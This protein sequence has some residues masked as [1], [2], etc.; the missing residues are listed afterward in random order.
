MLAAWEGARVTEMVVNHRRRE[1]GTT[2]YG[3]GRILNVLWD[4]VTVKFLGTYVT[5]PLYFFGKLG[6][7]SLSL[8][9][10]ALGVAIAQK[11]G[12]LG[13]PQGLHL[14]RNVLVAL[15]ALLC[16]C[17]VQCILFGIVSEFL[18]RIYHESRRTRPYRIRTI[19]RADAV[20]ESGS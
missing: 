15:A 9:A 1:R 12:Y 8:S 19:H 20:S 4:L 10:I 18:V 6:L 16:F 7:L 14:N 17:T 13:Q 2:K 3:L 5:K 11:Y